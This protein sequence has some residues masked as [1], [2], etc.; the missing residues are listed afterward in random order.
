MRDNCSDGTLLA[1]LIFGVE[2]TCKALPAS[3]SAHA[4]AVAMLLTAKLPVANLSAWLM[5]AA[6]FGGDPLGPQ[7]AANSQ[8]LCRTVCA[9]SR[10]GGTGID[11]SVRR[12]PRA[13]HPVPAVPK[14]VSGG[15]RLREEYLCRVREAS[16]CW[17]PTGRGELRGRDGS[18]L[19]ETWLGEGQLQS[20]DGWTGGRGR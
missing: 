1:R 18:L 5:G 10:S 6:A 11:R 9:G 12:L 8:L 16:M 7:R 13:T 20:G 3:P 19:T 17:Y 2:H 14:D 4:W 15:F